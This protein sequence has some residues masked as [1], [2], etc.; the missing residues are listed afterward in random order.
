MLVLVPLARACG[1]LAQSAM[2][3][4]LPCSVGVKIDESDAT[5]SVDDS[6]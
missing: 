6:S 1:L 3:L 4:N 5:H 2:K